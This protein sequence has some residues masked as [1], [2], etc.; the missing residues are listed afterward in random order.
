MRSFSPMNSEVDFTLGFSCSIVV[1]ATPVCAEITAKVSPARTVQYR[2]AGALDLVV[3]A[4]V[5]VAAG[6]VAVVVTCGAGA[7]RLPAC[8]PERTSSTATV[9]A[10]RNAA[11]PA[12]RRQPAT[13][14]PRRP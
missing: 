2:F 10:S 8:S 7:G 6:T 13:T 11:G 14:S 4:A 3:V 12:Y 1:T 9:A 5:V